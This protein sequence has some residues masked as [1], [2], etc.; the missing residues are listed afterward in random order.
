[1]TNWYLEFDI[2]KKHLTM[3][4]SNSVQTEPRPS[5]GEQEQNRENTCH[6]SLPAWNMIQKGARSWNCSRGN[7]LQIPAPSSVMRASDDELPTPSLPESATF[8]HCRANNPRDHH[9]LLHQL[10]I[11]EELSK[12]YIVEI[13]HQHPKMVQCRY[14]LSYSTKCKTVEL[15]PPAQIC[16]LNPSLDL[17]RLVHETFQEAIAGKDHDGQLP[18][19][20][21]CQFDASEAVVDYFIHQ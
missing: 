18:L 20:Y 2:F 6:C 9:H 1:M 4:D 16:C 13:V 8:D 15:Y 3:L 21:A 5:R 19:H 10:L 12:D 14:L 7:G 17:L 11:R